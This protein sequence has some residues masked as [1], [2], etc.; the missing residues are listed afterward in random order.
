MGS[1]ATSYIS[2]TSSSATRVADLANVSQGTIANF[3]ANP[4]CVFLDVNFAKLSSDGAIALLGNRQSGAWWRIYSDAS[5]FYFEVNG[6]NGYR[7]IVFLNSGTLTSRTKIAINR[8]GNII[9]IYVN[10][11]SAVTETNIAWSSDFTT[12]NSAVELNSWGGL[13]YIFTTTE[14][15]QAVFFKQSLTATE[16]ASLTTI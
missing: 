9:T 11:S 6:S 15:N 12:G 4:F 8:N 5:F 7:Q 10:G 16:L 1:Y 3:G 2:T 14:Y 13:N